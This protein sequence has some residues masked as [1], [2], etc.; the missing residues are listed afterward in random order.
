[1][2]ADDVLE[3]LLP[4]LSRPGEPGPEGLVTHFSFQFCHHRKAT[5]ENLL[6][7]L[8]SE[9]TRRCLVANAT[10]GGSPASPPAAHPAMQQQ[11]M[12]PA[13][14]GR[15]DWTGGAVGTPLFFLRVPGIRVGR[16]LWHPYR[17]P[18]LNSR[19]KRQTL[20][21]DPDTRGPHRLAQ[22]INLGMENWFIVR[23]KDPIKDILYPLHLTT[24][25]GSMVA[26]Q[27]P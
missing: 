16:E 23:M 8:P 6:K 17:R 5:G 13:P 2:R 4:G 14:R 15:Q 25:W 7:D 1:M 27:T 10:P 3:S 21:Y 22:L 20:S 12:L 11:R 24:Q 18:V 19:K 9:N 26:P